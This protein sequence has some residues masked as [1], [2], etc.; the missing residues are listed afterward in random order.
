[1]MTLTCP[2]CGAHAEAVGSSA[3]AY[4]NTCRV[5]GTEI[6]WDMDDEE[7]GE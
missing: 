4:W 7:A 6:V 5:C 2:Y 3:E 1:M